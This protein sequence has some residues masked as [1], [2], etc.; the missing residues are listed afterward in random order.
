MV[1][2]DIYL[3]QILMKIYAVKDFRKKKDQ[4][5]M[6]N[7]ST[8]SLEEKKR[9][10][11]LNSYGIKYSEFIREY[12]DCTITIIKKNDNEMEK[13]DPI[14]I[15][16]IKNDLM[17]VKMFL[18]YYRKIGIKKFVFLDDKSTDGTFEFLNEQPDVSIYIADKPYTTVR[19]QVWINKI[20]SELGTN[21]WYLIVDSDEIFD[22][23]DREHVTISKFINKLMANKQDLVKV[24]LLDMFSAKSLFAD[25]VYNYKD[26]FQEC[27]MFLPEYSYERCHYDI[28]IK[29][30]ARGLM[31]S[32][33]G[34][35][36]LP[37]VSKYPLI[38]V[39]KDDIIINSHCNLPAKRNKPNHPEAVL[40][41]YKFLPD[42][43]EKYIRRISEGNFENGSKEYKIYSQM[44][45]N[46]QY[47]QIVKYMIK[48]NDFSSALNITLLKGRNE[49]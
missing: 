45:N 41:H 42:D 22:Y 24:I 8:L 3:S 34:E 31:F 11:Y 27:N 23:L 38:Y 14:V 9:L 32:Q 19:R 2:F 10:F 7:C 46:I 37:V 26:I 21:R 49:K 39:K 43:R 33:M 18:E 4:K 44:E 6:I 35:K 16:I 25:N 36:I 12:L 28:R 47:Q 20:I 15:C 40:R 30:G 1:N 17:R 5:K 29:G 48:Y 13:L